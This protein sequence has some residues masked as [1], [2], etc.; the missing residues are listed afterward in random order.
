MVVQ[1]MQ[2]PSILVGC[3]RVTGCVVETTR[4]S[5]AYPPSMTRNPN[6]VELCG[7]DSRKEYPEAEAVWCALQPAM[8]KCHAELVFFS[9]GI[10]AFSPST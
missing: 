9:M 3:V 10:Y 6:D 4:E 1:I 2:A 5:G 8:L 7:P